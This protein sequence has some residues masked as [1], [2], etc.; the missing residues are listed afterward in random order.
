MSAELHLVSTAIGE[1]AYGRWAERPAY[2]DTDPS[3]RI[4]CLLSETFGGGSPL[5]PFRLMSSP[6]RQ[7][8]ILAYSPMEAG[9]IVQTAERV[10]SERAGRFPKSVLS[11]GELRTVR[12]PL[13]QTGQKLAV[14]VL[15]VPHRRM[16]GSRE[17]DAHGLALRRARESGLKPPTR[18]ASYTAWMTHRIERTGG[19]TLSAAWINSW[20]RASELRNKNRRPA[21]ITRAELG[22]VLT[23]RDPG[24]FTGLLARGI[25]RHRGY[26]YGMIMIE[27]VAP[28]D[29]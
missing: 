23:V 28:D 1:R 20:E 25:G 2:A 6:G 10:M 18:E 26:G 22:G 13:L 4:H 14:S 17:M 21:R 27:G 16:D 24:L 3:Y 11:L 15:A 12:V 19:A 8:S 7:R 5:S 9:L 29:S